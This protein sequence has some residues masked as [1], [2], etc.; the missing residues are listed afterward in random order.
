M[1]KLETVGI[2]VLKN[3]LSAYI[4]KVAL[5]VRV[6]VS[7]RGRIVVEMRSPEPDMPSSD[8]HPLLSEWIAQGLVHVGNRAGFKA[9]KSP[10]SL[11]AGTAQRLL[12]EDRG[13]R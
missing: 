6:F 2:R 8:A 3:N 10:V 12:D 7:D 4:R 1:G 11:P 5:G 13:E 9:Q